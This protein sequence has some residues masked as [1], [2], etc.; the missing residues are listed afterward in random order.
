M[1]QSEREDVKPR[2]DQLEVAT[3]GHELLTSGDL[4]PVYIGL[5]SI[6]DV[7]LPAWLVAYWCFYH[8]GVA[9]W[10]SD[11]PSNLFWDGML[12][13]AQNQHP[14][15]GP[16]WPRGVERRHYR[17][18]FAVESTEALARQFPD[19]G[20]LLQKLIDYRQF[21]DLR[22]WVVSEIKGFGP[23]IAFKI[24]DMLER[25][26][27]VEIDFSNAD[28]FLY[29]EPAAGADLVW[30]RYYADLA[31]D[32]PEL[33]RNLVVNDL[34]AAFTDHKAPPYQDRSINIQEV[35][36]V[37]C[38]WK[39]HVNGHYPLGKDTHEVAEALHAWSRLSETAA[40]MLEPILALKEAL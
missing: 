25:C 8:V 4:D 13:A 11:Q 24:A 38:K 12:K 36:T 1:R 35:E 40:V 7:K 16:S 9:S 2:Y 27:G 17:G 37:L 10:M 32:D 30:E 3:F 22:D 21:S 33:R 23:W 5:K 19:P 39:S 29:K 20:Q 28:V 26:C 14:I 6:D 31:E 15:L 34:C 18:R